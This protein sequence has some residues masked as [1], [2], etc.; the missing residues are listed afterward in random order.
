MDLT[1]K[2]GFDL[3]IDQGRVE[4]KDIQTCLADVN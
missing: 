1:R 4:L 2:G 3:L